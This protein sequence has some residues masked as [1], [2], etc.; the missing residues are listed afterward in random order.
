MSLLARL[1]SLFQPSP[2]DEEMEEEL[3]SHIAHRADD[4]ER[5]GLTRRQ[6]ERRARVEFGGYERLRQESRVALGRGLGEATMQDIRFGLRMLR[7]KPA[8]A[9]VAVLTLAFAIGANAVAFS[10]LNGLVL[11]PLDLP[12]PRNLYMIEE[13]KHHFQ[14]SYPDYLDMR[15]RTR[16]MEGVLAFN[17]GMAGMDAG[18]GPSRSTMYETSSNY[19]DVLQVQPYLGRFFHNA[20]EHGPESAPY[21]VLSHAYWQSQFQGDRSIIGRTI[22][23]N[24]YPYTVLG[25]AQPNFRGTSLFIIPDMWVPLVQQAQIEGVN[26]LNERIFRGI[27]V[28][29]RMKDGVTRTQLEQD[30]D[31]IA[32]QLTAEHPKENDGITFNLAR[33]ELMGDYA[34]AAARV[35]LTGL[36]VLSGLILLAACANLGSLFAARAADRSKE[37]AMRLALGSSRT[38][39]MRQLLTEATMIALAGGLLGVAGSV[40][41]LHALTTLEPIPD[42]PINLPIQPD[43]TVFVVSLLVALASGFLFGMVPL[44]QVMSSNPYQVIKAGANAE[45]RR[46]TLRDALLI[47]QI[48]ICAVLVTASLIAVRGLARTLHGHFGIHPENVMDASTDLVMAHYTADQQPIMQKKMLDAVAKLPGATVGIADTLPLGMQTN[49]SNVFAETTTDLRASNAAAQIEKFHVSPGYFAAAGTAFLAGRDLTWHDDPTAPKVA[50]VNKEFARKVFG[51]VEKAVGSHF[52]NRDGARIEVAG[53]VEDGKYQN[54]AEAP[55]PVVFFPILQWP[56]SATSLVV[57]MEGDPQ[58]VTK[59]IRDAL[60]SVDAGLPMVIE[61]WT[62]ELDTAL[63]PARV[64]AVSLGV[65]GALGAMLS[66]TGIFGM[67]AYSVSKRLREFGIRMALGAQKT[68]VLKAAMSRTFWLLTIGST[69]GMALGIGAGRVLAFL[70]YQATPWDPVVL[71]GVLGTMLCVGLLA[72]WIP[73]R[74]ALGVDPLILLREE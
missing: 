53:V 19:F 73:A 66:V 49:I 3:R 6:A 35:F 21:V 47:G 41:L 38:R 17:F 54:Y 14:Q 2:L 16:T 13:G 56:Q 29:G 55:I 39:I 23:L 18:H 74:R 9:V 31:G 62:K 24:K 72:G 48:T 59:Q 51:S 22:Q 60:R 52:K 20:D 45:G 4:L 37:V 57:R 43:T 46:F 8:F 44:R 65:L 33:P 7:K 15:D 58:Q 42:F 69:V 71:G 25:V 30:L 5:T 61:P 11:K 28:V 67:A 10:V 32:R 50:I 70:V 40:P 27:W 1:R 26:H 68:E 34:G 36:M 64:A 12:K 63:F